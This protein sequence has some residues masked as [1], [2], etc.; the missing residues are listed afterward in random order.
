[1][2]KNK[3][4]KHWTQIGIE[5]SELKDTKN[6]RVISNYLEGCVEKEKKEKEK[7]QKGELKELGGSDDE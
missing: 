6:R 1:M 2:A 3:S 4:G 5:V 7:E